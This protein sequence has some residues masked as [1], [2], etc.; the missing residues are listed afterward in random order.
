MNG[1]R[2]G[3]PVVPWRCLARSLDHSVIQIGECIPPLLEGG[4]PPDSYFEKR[5]S[6]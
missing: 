5:F 1:F 4:F 3:S 2:A 6:G